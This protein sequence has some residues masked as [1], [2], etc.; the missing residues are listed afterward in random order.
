MPQSLPRTAALLCLT[1]GG[2][3]HAQAGNFDVLKPFPAAEPGMRRVVIEMPELPDQRD[4][5]VE[6]VIGQTLEAD[7]N[8]QHMSAKVERR[9]LQGWGFDY[10]VVQELSAPASTQMGCPE[11]QKAR[12]EFVSA[13]PELLRALRYNPRLPLV[14]YVPDNS[15]VRYRIWA[16]GAFS[17]AT[18][19]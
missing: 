19:R 3:L 16:P 17:T 1:L 2:G 7:C 11:N 9:V 5:R 15:E 12:R 13:A 10:Y 4:R 6:V 18:A 8:K 14:L